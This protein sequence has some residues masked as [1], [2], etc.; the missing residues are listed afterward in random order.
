M[1]RDDST[2]P[3]TPGGPG[4]FSRWMQ[5]TANARANRRIRKGRGR[6][7]GMDLLILHTTGRRSGAPRETPLMHLEE[8]DGSLLVVASGGGDRNPDWHAN[9]TAR[10][11][12]VA[13]EL[14]GQPRVPAVA[15]EL[16]G[17]D[18]ER[19]WQR[20]ATDQPRIAKYQKKATREYPLIRLTPQ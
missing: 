11:G 17:P 2:A 16:H 13:I 18:R 20:L 14:P 5:H 19:A 12:E 1:A 4:A 10:P 15:E 7:M 8:P 6:S 3:R 9:L